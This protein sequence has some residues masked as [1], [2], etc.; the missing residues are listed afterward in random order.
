MSMKFVFSRFFL[1]S[2]VLVSAACSQQARP[3]DSGDSTVPPN[4]GIAAGV[5]PPVSAP[6]LTNAI[7][8]N[9][10][11]VTPATTVVDP[12]PSREPVS[13]EPDSR[14]PVSVYSGVYTAAQAARGKH[15]Q[16]TECVACHAPGD[17]ADGNVIS[18]FTGLSAYDLVERIRTTMPMDGPGRLSLQ[19][20]T[21]LAAFI[22]ELNGAPPGN[23]ELPADPAGLAGVRLEYRN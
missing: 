6:P 3:E 15:V 13:S 5:D 2:L 23:S 20:Y 12:R 9:S 8:P 16:E 17:W 21:D 11:A 14:G 1:L 19:Q 4:E 7:P 10:G 18:G 22:F